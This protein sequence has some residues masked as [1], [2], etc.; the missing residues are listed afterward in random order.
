MHADDPEIWFN[1][2]NSPD[3]HGGG[4]P[5]HAPLTMVWPDGQ[6]NTVVEPL[7][8]ADDPEIWFSAQNSP[9]PHAGT[10]PEVQDAPEH[11]PPLQ[12]SEAQRLAPGVE[13][14]RQRY[15]TRSP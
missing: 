10:P 4:V 8:H 14:N 9:D 7:R 1:A 12:L 5:E 6:Q 3:P 11:V 2:Q 13:P 15:C